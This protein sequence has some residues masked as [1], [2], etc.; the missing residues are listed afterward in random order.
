MLGLFVFSRI[1]KIEIYVL[2]GMHDGFLND[3]TGC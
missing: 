3:K 1:M 2:R